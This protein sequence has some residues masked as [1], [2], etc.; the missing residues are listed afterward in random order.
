MLNG[1]GRCVGGGG[2]GGGLWSLRGHNL[3][4]EFLGMVGG[5]GDGSGSPGRVCLLFVAREPHSL[6]MVGVLQTDR[7]GGGSVSPFCNHSGEVGEFLRKSL[8][9]V[10]LGG[11]LM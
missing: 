2:F 6:V 7:C 9:I 11:W 10:V 8:V 1:C 3:A 4:H 5:S